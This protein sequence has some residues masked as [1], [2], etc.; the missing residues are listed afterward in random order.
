MPKLS[1]R[2]PD[3]VPS[4]IRASRAVQEHQRLYEGFIR[5]INTDVGELELTP[6]ENL[7]SVKVRLRRA[8]SRFGTPV[9]IWD[10]ND[11]VYFRR[12]G[13]KRRGRPRKGE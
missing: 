10:A 2:K 1:L 8:A 7:R 3:E 9:D 12:E 13:Q 11:R 6:D 4:P 5:D